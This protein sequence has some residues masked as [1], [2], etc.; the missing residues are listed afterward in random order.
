MARRGKMWVYCP[1]KPPKPKV[2]ETL[3]AEVSEK[4]EQL[5]EST[6]KRQY[7]KA[8]PKDDRF[9]YVVDLYTKW[10]RC[11]FYFC[12]KY[13]CPGPSAISPFFE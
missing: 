13:A 3:K 12:A 10:Y 11:Y 1:P 4:A 6:L 5:I 9:N 7:I 2:P 8:P